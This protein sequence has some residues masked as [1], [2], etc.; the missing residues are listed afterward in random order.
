MTASVAVSNFVAMPS[1]AVTHIQN[2]AP[3]PPTVMATATP[4]N[5]AQAECSG[6]RR[7]QCLEVRDIALVAG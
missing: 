7:C 1:T 4:V 3:G 6:Q 2:T 5:A